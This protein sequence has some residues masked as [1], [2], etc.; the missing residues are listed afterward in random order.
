MTTHAIMKGVG[1][2]DS[3]ATALSATITWIM[4]DGV[5]MVGRIAFAWWK[6]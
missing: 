3:A 4:K 2:G 6:G 1:V 5:G